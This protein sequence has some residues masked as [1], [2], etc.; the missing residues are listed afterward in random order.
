MAKPVAV[1]KTYYS[2]EDFT[3]LVKDAEKAGLR[4]TGLFLYVKKKGH[5]YG[6][7]VVPNTKR[8]AK[9]TKFCIEYWR[10]HEVERAVEAA[11][12]K[13]DREKTEKRLEELGMS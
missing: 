4:R 10:K 12:L 5:E 11:R 6:D 1:I 7:A 8:L 2:E 13:A 3:R 9:F